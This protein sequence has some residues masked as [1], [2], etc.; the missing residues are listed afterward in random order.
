MFF[1]QEWFSKR[2][3]SLL[4]FE[5][6]LNRGGESVQVVYHFFLTDDTSQDTETVL[7]AKHFLYSIVLPAYG[8]KK[9][10]FRSDGAG[11]FA[12]KEAK[13]CMSLFGAISNQIDA[14]YEISYKVSVAGCGKTALDVS[15]IS[16]LSIFISL[17]CPSSQH[18]HPFTIPILWQMHNQ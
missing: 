2:G 4:S 11:C 1:I 16:C 5:V 9:V 7:C 3:T 17:L 14:A 15:L 10:Y 12:S 8:K 13:S 18:H 6:H